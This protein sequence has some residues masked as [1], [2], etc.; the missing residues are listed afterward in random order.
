MKKLLLTAAVVTA[1]AMSLSAQETVKT[2]YEGEAK[3]VTWENTLTIPADQFAEGVKVGDY[4]SIPLENATDVL[5]IKANGTWLPGSKLTNIENATEYK[6]YI[7]DAMLASLKE[8]GLEICGASFT[9]TGVS[10]K[11]DGFNMPEGAIW[12]GYFWV[13]NWNTL[14]LFKTAFDN[15]TNQRYLDI[16][17]EAGYDTYILNVMT[18]F[19]DASALWSK[20][21]NTT[22][23]GTTAIVD[24]NGINVKE[25][26]SD[27]NTLLIQL[28]PEGGNPFNVT[29]IVLRNEPGVNTAVSEIATETSN[30]PAAVYNLQ[31]VK[32]RD[33]LPSEVNSYNL[34]AGIYI[35]NGKKIAVR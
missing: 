3:N 24:L 32:V 29:S 5:E 35:V 2:L 22:K 27:V 34:P 8:Y 25:A 18:K 9:V 7:T 31:G 16:N 14:E 11:N 26:L 30:V 28:N 23:T 12:G 10:V 1:T 17:M 19:D 15:Y 20:A 13:E 4:I 33:L 21:D 6:A